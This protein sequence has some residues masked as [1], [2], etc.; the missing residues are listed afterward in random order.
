MVPLS[1]SHVRPTDIKYRSWNVRDSAA[2]ML[3]MQQ[4]SDLL[5]LQQLQLDDIQQN[6][7]KGNSLLTSRLAGISTIHDN[8]HYARVQRKHRARQRRMYL[9]LPQWLTDRTWTL[10]TYQSQGSWTVEIHPEVW[11]PFE[12]PALEFIRLGDIGNLQKSLAAGELSIWDTTSCPWDFPGNS[13]TLLGV[14]IAD[15]FL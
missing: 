13:M 15:K 5:A 8:P 14:C 9:R 1:A 6:I 7:S 10:S 3:A 4:H 2:Q 12:T 11:R